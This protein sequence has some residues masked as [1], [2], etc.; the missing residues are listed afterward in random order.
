MAFLS[1]NRD[2]ICLEVKVGVLESY[3]PDEEIKQLFEEIKLLKKNFKTKLQNIV[4]KVGTQKEAVEI[5][6]KNEKKREKWEKYV[7]NIFT[8]DYKAVN[9]KVHKKNSEICP[10]F[11]DFFNKE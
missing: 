2:Q 6:E 9:D 4:G 3:Q 10:N 1:I 5:L 11:K 8:P 7:Q